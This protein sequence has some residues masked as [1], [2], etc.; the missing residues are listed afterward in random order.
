LHQ[1]REIQIERVCP[2]GYRF[3]AYENA[4]G[5]YVGG[6]DLSELR[7]V[8]PRWPSGGGPSLWFCLPP[9]RQVEQIPKDDQLAQLEFIDEYKPDPFRDFTETVDRKQAWQSEVGRYIRWLFCGPMP[10]SH[11]DMARH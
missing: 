8:D 10:E 7:T 6:F 3:G 11:P 5:N 4:Y 2:Y 1:A 9:P